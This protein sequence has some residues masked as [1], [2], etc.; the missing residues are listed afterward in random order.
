MDMGK[1]HT[2]KVLAGIHLCMH[3]RS[4]ANKEKRKRLGMDGELDGE[5]DAAEGE[6]EDGVEVLDS[7]DGEEGP[8]SSKRQKLVGMVGLR[9]SACARGHIGCP[10]LKVK[11]LDQALSLLVHAE[12]TLCACV[13]WNSPASTCKLCTK[14]AEQN[15]DA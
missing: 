8:K 1:K 7:E 14:D 2:E 6:D 9:G 15:K 4:C 5:D 12:G 13:V 10:K 11:S 3:L